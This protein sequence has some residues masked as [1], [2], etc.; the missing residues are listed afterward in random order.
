MT[1]QEYGP[2]PCPRRWSARTLLQCESNL[3]RPLFVAIAVWLSDLRKRCVFFV[4]VSACLQTSACPL[5][6]RNGAKCG[7]SFYLGV[8]RVPRRCGG[9]DERRL[10]TMSVT[11]VNAGCPC[12]NVYIYSLTSIVPH[13]NLFPHLRPR[14]SPTPLVSLLKRRWRERP[15]EPCNKKQTQISEKKKGTPFLLVS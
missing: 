4:Y 1:G 13:C 2:S 3:A 15:E 9:R 12:I 6:S 8:T 14:S 10:L 7:W 5:P 11:S